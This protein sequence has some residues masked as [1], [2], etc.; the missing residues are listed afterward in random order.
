MSALIMLDRI[1]PKSFYSS[2]IF[3]VGSFFICLFLFIVWD[4]DL[5]S[6]F[7]LLVSILVI[8]WI[9]FIIVALII[10]VWVSKEE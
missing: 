5:F 9:I 4:I 2:I 6:W 3:T 10:E 1:M 8:I 7:F